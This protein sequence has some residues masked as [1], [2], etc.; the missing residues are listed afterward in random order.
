M[1]DAAAP[2]TKD[3]MIGKY[4]VVRCRDA[5]VHAG[6]LVEQSG[7]EC[8]LNNSRRLWRWFAKDGISLSEVAAN[9]IV[10]EKSRIAAPV[11]IVLTEICEIILCSQEGE[12]TIREAAT[13]VPV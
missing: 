4:V 3:S 10:P 8:T 11:P 1:S 9:G 2:I 13:Y 7:R 5:G 12:Q 6:H